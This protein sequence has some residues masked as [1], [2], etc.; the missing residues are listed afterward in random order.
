MKFLAEPSV[1]LVVGVW[2][3]ASAMVG[4]PVMLPETTL[5]QMR[6]LPNAWQPTTAGL[7]VKH[8][9]SDDS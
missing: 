9:Y 6:W 5:V 7:S 3:E 2:L 8:E 4:L 1:V